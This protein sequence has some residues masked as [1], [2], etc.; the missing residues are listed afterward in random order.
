MLQELFL[1]K[2]YI[3]LQGTPHLNNS[4]ICRN[5]KNEFL[6]AKQNAKKVY[7]KLIPKQFDKCEQISCLTT[8]NNNLAVYKI[9]I[10]DNILSFILTGYSSYDYK[11]E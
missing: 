9:N 8:Y 10:Y 1:L 4:E 7:I 6:Y 2:F 11:R 5:I 3:M